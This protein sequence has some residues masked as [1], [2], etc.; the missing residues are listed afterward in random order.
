M[1][2]MEITHIP[3]DA[4]LG[5]NLDDHLNLQNNKIESIEPLAFEGSVG[6]HV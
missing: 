3:T 2:N 5:L 6:D 4:F 1:E